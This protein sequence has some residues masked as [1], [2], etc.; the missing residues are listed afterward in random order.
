MMDCWTLPC[1]LNLKACIETCIFMVFVVDTVLWQ[2]IFK[3]VLWWIGGKKTLRIS[4][5]SNPSAFTLLLPLFFPSHS[6]AAIRPLAECHPLPNTSLLSPK[7]SPR[8]LRQSVIRGLTTLPSSHILSFLILSVPLPSLPSPRNKHPRPAPPRR[9]GA[10]GA[11]RR[12]LCACVRAC[13]CVCLCVGRRRFR[14]SA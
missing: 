3:L 5:T 4:I 2:A 11:L 10:S 14:R 1:L 8:H 12:K 9:P 7:S 6:S 13:V